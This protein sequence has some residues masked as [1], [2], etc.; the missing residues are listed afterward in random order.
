[1]PRMSGLD[2]AKSIFENKRDIKILALTIEEDDNS[3]IQLVQYG[4][5]GYLLR[6]LAPRNCIMP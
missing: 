1:M 5:K 4:L 3:V 6:T 2:A